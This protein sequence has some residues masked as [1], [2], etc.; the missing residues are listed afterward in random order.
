MTDDEDAHIVAND[1]E[2]QMTGKT[3]E[4]IAP[5]ERAYERVTTGKFAHGIQG[6][7]EFRME[8]VARRVGM[9]IIPVQNAAHITPDARM[10]DQ[11][12]P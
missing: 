3:F 12:H 1:I 9:R 8:A 10:N 4:S 11:L 7:H 2:N 6:G 5:V